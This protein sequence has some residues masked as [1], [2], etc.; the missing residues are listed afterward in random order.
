ME[1]D[2][3]TSYTEQDPITHFFNAHVEAVYKHAR[4]QAI[5]EQV[6]AELR[7]WVVA[8]PKPKIALPASI[9]QPET[10]P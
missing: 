6:D 3:S 8:S 9:P 4:A 1:Q 10:S 7:Q 2:N 5:A